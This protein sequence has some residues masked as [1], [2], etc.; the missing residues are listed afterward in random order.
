[1]EV[2]SLHYDYSE[3]ERSGYDELEW[4]ESST[5]ATTLW[6]VYDG[7]REEGEGSRARL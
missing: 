1:L 4:I 3:I 6:R 2:D 7:E 5:S